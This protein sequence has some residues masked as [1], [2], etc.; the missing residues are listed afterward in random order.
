MA[1]AF[2]PPSRLS[3]TNRITP[4]AAISDMPPAT[5]RGR[6]KP[7]LPSCGRARRPPMAGPATKPRAKAAPSMPMRPERKRGGVMSAI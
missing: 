2:C 5:N 3:R 4:R 6:W 1:G 7:A